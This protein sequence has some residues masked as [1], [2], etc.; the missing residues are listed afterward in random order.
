MHL[1]SENHCPRGGQNLASVFILASVPCRKMVRFSS[2]I[3]SKKNPK[4]WPLKRQRH[5]SG[6]RVALR[7]KSLH[8]FSLDPRAHGAP[9]IS[10]HYSASAEKSESPCSFSP[11]LLFLRLPPSPPLASF[12]SLPPSCFF[13]LFSPSSSFLLFVFFFFS[14]P[15][16]SCPLFFLF[17][18]F[19]L[20]FF[21]LFHYFLLF[22]FPPSFSFSFLVISHLFFILSPELIGR[23]NL[24]KKRSW[25][26]KG[27]RKWQMP[28][29][30]SYGHP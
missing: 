2:T 18:P 10:G 24:L 17:L 1:T 28:L 30:S 7:L 9:S 29:L 13:I 23:V 12:L 14:L 16:F 26:P 11:S 22:F 8:L 3:A 21:F 15:S 20:C 5:L 6:G 19:A 4:L 25:M 27:H